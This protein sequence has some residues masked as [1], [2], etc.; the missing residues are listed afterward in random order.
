[1]KQ[2]VH[3]GG[4]LFYEPHEEIFERMLYTSAQRNTTR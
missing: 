1:M 4:I 2:V 3:I